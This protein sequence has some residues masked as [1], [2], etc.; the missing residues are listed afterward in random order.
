MPETL[1]QYGSKYWGTLKIA[2]SHRK[3]GTTLGERS[4]SSVHMENLWYLF[5]GV[6]DEVAVNDEGVKAT[7]AR[8]A[9][10]TVSE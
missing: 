5:S 3:R 8:K 7:E 6:L 2:E 10:K 1:I 4:G 9:L